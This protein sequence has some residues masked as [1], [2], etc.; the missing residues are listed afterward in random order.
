MDAWR[1]FLVAL[2]ALPLTP[3]QLAIYKAHTGRTNPPTTPHREAWLVIGRRGGKS[4]I[5]AVIA[6][7]LACFFDWRPY[8]GPAKSA[9]SWLFVPT[10]AKPAPSCALRWAC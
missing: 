8:L 6:V 3:D 2:F 1:T 5:L 4:F 9:P 7:F 10:D